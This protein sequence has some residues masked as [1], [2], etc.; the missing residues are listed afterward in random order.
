MKSWTCLALALGLSSG[1]AHAQAPTVAAEPAP[2]FP[3]A[4]NGVVNATVRPEVGGSTVRVYFRW[5]E[6]GAMYWV[7]MVAAGDGAYWG[8]PA[9]PEPENERIE[10]Y[11]SVLDPYGRTLA[12]SENLFS[13]VEEDCVV[14][15]TPVQVAASNNLTV[16]ETVEAQQARKVLGFL[17]DG[18]VT[19]VNHEGLMRPDEICR[20]CV[21]PWYA[22][23]EFLI[24]TVGT[25]GAA[26]AATTTIITG[27]TPPEPSPSRP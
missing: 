27:T 5:D 19:R 4:E 7:D 18:V 11:V 9:K 12:R 13:P 17:C 14:A 25:T 3:E 6:H 10:Y 23:E 1:L 2:C 8:I 21:I 15:L 16:G 26:V 20:G 24:G 22:R